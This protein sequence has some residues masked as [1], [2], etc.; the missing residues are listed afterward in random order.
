MAAATVALAADNTTPK[1]AIALEPYGTISWTGIN[2]EAELGAGASLVFGITKNLSVVGFGEADNTENTFLDRFGAGLRY[3]APL[4]S[5]VSLDAGVGGGYDTERQNFFVRLP[6]GANLYAYK[7][8]NADLG[9]RVQYAFDIDGNG[10]H[11]SATGRL[12]A[13]PVLNVKF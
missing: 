9:L 8:K 13:G 1:N 6:V 5:R 2:G 3:T 12:F 11:G 7:S 4:G 10:K